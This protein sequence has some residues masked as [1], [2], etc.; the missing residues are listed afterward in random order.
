MNFPAQKPV[1]YVRLYKRIAAV[2]L[3]LTLVL[4]GLMIY[5]SFSKATITII[6]TKEKVSLDFSV[7]VEKEPASRD[8]VSGALFSV[9]IQGEIKEPATGVYV[10]ENAK[11]TGEAIIYNNT[12]N[13]QTLVKTTRLL[14]QDNILFRLNNTV[15]VP[16]KGSANAQ[17]YA[18]KP[19]T[20]SE[21]SSSK[22]TIPGLPL[23]LQSEI[24]AELSGP[25]KIQSENATAVSKEDIA[26]AAEKLS[27]EL[28]EKGKREL[29]LVAPQNFAG[30]TYGSEIVSFDSDNNEGERAN[31]FNFS[32]ELRVVGIFYDIEA[33][34]QTAKT[35]LEESVISEL[36]LVNINYNG[37][38]TEVGRFDLISENAIL[39]VYIEGETILKSTNQIFD[40]NKLAGMEKEAAINYFKTFSAVESVK[41]DLQ[42]FWSK[43]IPSVKDNIEIIIQK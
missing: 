24:Y 11:A 41:I 36:E 29:E 27:I 8:T 1:V 21:V 28:L 9:K 14:T 5:L 32:M 37:L 38:K 15:S 25:T 17:V 34:R 40:K 18:D 23:S 12:S 19:G 6:P 16:A 2:F 3:G 13:S 33:L 42:P 30:R 39:K 35:K 10:A 7:N 31:E 22:M 20:S 4:L 26:R 43:S